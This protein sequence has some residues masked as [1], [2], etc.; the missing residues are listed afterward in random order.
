M[1]GTLVW[2]LQFSITL[3]WTQGKKR[4]DWSWTI[5]GMR[6]SC[7]SAKEI[8]QLF[9]LDR[10]RETCWIRIKAENSR[11]A[12]FSLVIKAFLLKAPRLW[13]PKISK[14]H[15]NYKSIGIEHCCHFGHYFIFCFLGLI[16]NNYSVSQIQIQYS[17]PTFWQ[18]FLNKI[19]IFRNFV[20]GNFWW[21]IFMQVTIFFLYVRLAISK[22]RPR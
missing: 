14:Y 10:G 4:S 13:E 17:T 15:N 11:I 19:Y 22:L 21:I 2:D 9:E 5:L 20:T 8:K 12:V 6:V 18:S 7:Q 3:M 16:R 1:N